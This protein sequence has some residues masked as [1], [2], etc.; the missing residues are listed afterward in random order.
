[1]GDKAPGADDDALGKPGENT[2]ETF[3]ALMDAGYQPDRTLSSHDFT[4]AKSSVYW[5]ALIS[6][7][8]MK[9]GISNVG[10]FSVDMTLFR[11]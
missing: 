1:V 7:K 6:H 4:R 2:L 9:D 11:I 5:A 3:R 10:C 8:N